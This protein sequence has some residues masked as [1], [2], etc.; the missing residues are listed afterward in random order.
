[1]NVLILC[2]H[3]TAISG[4]TLLALRLGVESMIA[5]LSLLAVAMNLFVLK[6]I[7]LF[8]L[9]VTSSDALA[10]GYLLGLNLIQEFFG[11]TLARKCMWISLFCSC[12]FVLLSQLHLLYTPNNSDSTQ[13]HFL[14]LLHPMPRI[15]F[16]SLLSFLVVQMVDLAFYGFLKRKTQGSYLP[17]RSAVALI[18]S[19]TL[20]TFLFSYLALFGIVESISHIIILSLAVKGVVIFLTVP[21]VAYSKKII[22]RSYVEI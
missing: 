2:L 4:L 21:F 3:I 6:Q 19:Q 10:V 1:M 20:D 17:V 13:S 11:R 16:A 18:I 8:G 12:S 14:A 22:S 5:W 15:I 7:T 9:C